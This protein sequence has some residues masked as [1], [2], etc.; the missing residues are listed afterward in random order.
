MEMHWHL[1]QVRFL[2]STQEPLASNQLLSSR[3]SWSWKAGVSELV[4]ISDD[5]DSHRFRWL[6]QTKVEWIIE[7]VPASNLFA[8][9]VM[10]LSSMALLL[11]QPR[12]LAVPF[13]L[14]HGPRGFGGWRPEVFD[15]FVRDR[16]PSIPTECSRYWPSA[17]PAHSDDSHGWRQWG[18]NVLPQQFEPLCQNNGFHPW[19][20]WRCNHGTNSVETCHIWGRIQWPQGLLAAISR[21]WCNL[22]SSFG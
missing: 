21:L 8:H 9:P 18:R 19:F 10:D 3:D 22:G 17:S 6:K 2:A 13:R 15:G 1:G 12:C 14:R 4:C 20:P 7:L 5:F 16:S 11:R